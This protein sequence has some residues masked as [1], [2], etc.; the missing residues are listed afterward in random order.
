MSIELMEPEAPTST[1]IVEYSETEAALAALRARYANV[2]WDCTTPKGDKDARAVRLELVTLRTALDK[3][4]LALNADDQA[5]IKA[6]N[7][8]AKRITGEITSM[9]EPV[10]AAIRAQEIAKAAEKAERERV[11]RE[12]AAQV[13][14]SIAAMRDLLI[15]ASGKAPAV[16]DGLIQ[17]LEA[18]EIT[19]EVSGDRAGEAQQAK[20][21]TM[22]RLRDMHAAA[23]AQEAEAA[24]LA[25]ERAE[26]AKLRAEQEAREKAEAERLAAERKRIA[27][28]EAAAK[29]LRDKADA[30]ARAERDRA[31]A[32]ARQARAAEDKRI[33]DARAAL[34]AEQRAARLEKEAKEAAARKAEQDKADK[35]AAAERKRL[36]KIAAD[37][38]AEAAR[39]EQER[40]AAAQAALEAIEKQAADRKRLHD[41]APAMLHA[42]QSFENDDQHIPAAIW[43][44]RC[45]AIELATGEPA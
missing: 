14:A 5:R 6:R 38:R 1:G 15:E 9:E 34:E 17:R 36:D 2:V 31:E 29:A 22:Q 42:L 41:A 27:T 11:E 40:A 13:T 4:R 10:D 43:Q 3:K 37:A 26:L 24:R 12:K 44:L 18:I 32:E 7:D 8:K 33:A 28:E 39:I 23:I 19:L 20:T 16:V 25:A 35:A 21:Q 30:E 45:E